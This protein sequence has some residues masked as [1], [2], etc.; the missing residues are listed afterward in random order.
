MLPPPARRGLGRIGRIQ[1]EPRGAARRPRATGSARGGKEEALRGPA[2][3]RGGAGG[4]ASLWRRAAGRGVARACRQGACVSA[5]LPEALRQRSQNPPGAQR[6]AGLDGRRGPLLGL[7]SERGR[8][9]GPQHHRQD[10]ARSLSRGGVV[11]RPLLGLC[12]AR[13]GRC[14]GPRQHRQAVARALATG[15]GALGEGGTLLWTSA[16]WAG[17]C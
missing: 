7:R 13:A 8:C 17:R 10:F 15:R 2:Q 11:S 5:A 3:P 9:Y 4:G 16:A 6:G 12:T 14:H 1:P